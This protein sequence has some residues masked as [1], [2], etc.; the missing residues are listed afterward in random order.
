VRVDPPG[1]AAAASHDAPGLAVG[2]RGEVHVL[3]T[4]R[5]PEAA[6]AS[7]LLLSSSRDAGASFGAPLTV[8][9]AG[10]H[11][12]DFASLAPAPD[13]ALLVAWLEI[14]GLRASAKSARVDPEVRRVSDVSVLE[15]SACV[16]CRTALAVGPAGA[17]ALLWRG[18]RA[19]NVRDMYWARSAD[20]GRRFAP[21]R[22]VHADGWKLDACPHRGGS[23][24]FDDAGRA[25]AAWYTEGARA[26]PSLLLAGAE[27]NA[28]FDPPRELREAADALPDRPALA[29]AASG[30]GLVAFESATS[31]R[32]TIVARGFAPG[33]RAVGPGLL[34]SRALQAYG[35]AAVALPKGGFAVAWHEEAFPSL[36]TIVVELA[37]R[38]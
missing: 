26:R 29:V 19:G 6:G 9:A 11:S 25:A 31:V 16:C 24:A 15:E 20:A 21:P 10:P 35:P 36:R 33:A 13:G 17:A 23:V 8:A 14:G 37:L 2:P 7:A 38:P 3:W 1:S 34:L 30:T 32:R 28:D 4:A 5:P 22:L 18:E 27:P 12:H